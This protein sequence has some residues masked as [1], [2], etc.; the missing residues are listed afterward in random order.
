M[1]NNISSLRLFLKKGFAVEIKDKTLTY[2][3]NKK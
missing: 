1:K 2:F 3:M